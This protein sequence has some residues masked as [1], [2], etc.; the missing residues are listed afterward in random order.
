[1][2]NKLPERSVEEIVEEFGRFTIMDRNEIRLY[3]DAE[4]AENWL[5]QTLQTE[6]QKRD[7]MVGEARRDKERL[8]FLDRCN[9]ALND[10][11]QTN[12]G[13]KLILNHNVTRLMSERG[14]DFIDLHDSE[15]GNKKF[16]SC[17]EAIDEALT[18]P[19]TPLT[20]DKD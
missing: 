14:L 8:D 6:R 12:Y 11:Y 3:G 15:G 9:L 17:R 7:E 20:N 16:K 10:H 1:M 13:W 18:Q 19:P 5:T 2:N 4:V